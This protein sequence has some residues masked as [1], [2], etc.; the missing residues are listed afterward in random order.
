MTRSRPL[1]CSR[2]GAA[3]PELASGT[4]TLLQ[5]S[6]CGAELAL[7][8]FPAL[9]RAAAAG[10]A[11]QLVLEAGEAACFYHAEKRA[12]VPCETCGRFL[13]ALCDV[14]LHGK[15]YCPA[16][17]E[18]GRNK[19][20]S[21]PLERGR[22]RY[23]Q[24]VWSLLILPVPL[25]MLVAPVTAAAAFVLSLWKWRAPPSLVANTRL[26]FILGM[27]MAL[28]ELGASALIWGGMFLR[29]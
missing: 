8:V 24:I 7:T 11:P 3:L 18:S 17:L 2:C 15:H 1:A 26:R 10:P 9:N 13:C 29:R 27:V 14:Q 20:G 5:C 6:G 19:P 25:C 12:V 28:I 4:S 22:T 16:C 23:D 21:I